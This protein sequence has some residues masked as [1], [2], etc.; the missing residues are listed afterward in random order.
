[1]PDR[2]TESGGGLCD[3]HVVPPLVVPTAYGVELR[4]VP[5]AMQVFA[6]GQTTLLSCIPC[7]IEEVGLQLLPPFEVLREVAPPVV[8]I[9]VAVQADPEKQKTPDSD[10]NTG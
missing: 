7:G 8:A 6:A 1:M 9:P 5:T 10:A 4:F 2:S 3:V